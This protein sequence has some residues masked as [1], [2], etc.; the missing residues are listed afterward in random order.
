MEDLITKKHGRFE[1]AI[2][3][4]RLKLFKLQKDATLHCKKN[5]VKL[6]IKVKI[7]FK[8]QKSQNHKIAKLQ[9]RKIEKQSNHSTQ[10]WI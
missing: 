9:N 10:N 6:E 1:I 5:T 8:L 2:S 4:K 7:I 3:L